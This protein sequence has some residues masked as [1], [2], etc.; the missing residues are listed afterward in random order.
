[1]IKCNITFNHNQICLELVAAAS[2]AL[3]E[4]HV[5]AGLMWSGNNPGRSAFWVILIIPP[6]PL[7]RRACGESLMLF[8]NLGLQKSTCIVSCDILAD[9]SDRQRTLKLKHAKRDKLRLR[10]RRKFEVRVV[11]FLSLWAHC[12]NYTK[13]H[14]SLNLQES[15]TRAS[16]HFG[17][18]YK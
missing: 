16:L 2:I 15:L 9:I 11:I 18:G 10:Q 13:V 14:T 17:S 6:L 8:T 5:S 3:G 7:I 1:M 4:N 12:L